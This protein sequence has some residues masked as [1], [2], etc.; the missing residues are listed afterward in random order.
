MISNTQIEK[1]LAFL[2]KDFVTEI[3]NFSTV[4][5]IEKNTEILREGQFV[6]VIPIVISGLIK[7]FTRYEDKEIL[8]YYIKPTESCI[9]SFSASLANTPSQVYAITEETTTAVLLPVSK[10]LQWKQQFPILNELFFEQYNIRYNELLKTINHLLFDTLDVRIYNYLIE[11]KELTHK[12]PLKITHKQI[13]NELG[14][15]REVVSRLIKKLESENKVKQ[16]SNQ[17][18]IM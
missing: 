5:E 7:V 13:A 1:Q 18:K 8:L 11:K 3:L 15:A 12:N 14:T 6:K 16:L 10:V 2:G 9:K 4:L 17:I